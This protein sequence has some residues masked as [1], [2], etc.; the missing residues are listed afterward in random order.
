MNVSINTI[1][2]SRKFR[3]RRFDG[4]MLLFTL[5]GSTQLYG[6]GRWAP[7]VGGTIETH[8]LECE[9]DAMLQP[10]PVATIGR[11]LRAKLEG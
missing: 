6:P 8:H 4:D 5:S 1:P 7:Y 10:L 11:A 9:H 3:P 2:L